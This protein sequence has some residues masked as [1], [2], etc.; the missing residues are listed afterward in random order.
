MLSMRLRARATRAACL[1]PLLVLSILA[2]CSED[3]GRDREPT[4]PTGNGTGQ[5]AIWT[6]ANM[7]GGISVWLDGRSV[8]RL[9]MYFTSGV[10][11]CGDE[12]TITVT[13]DAGAYD[14]EA[15]TPGG[16]SWQGTVNV[17]EGRCNL[18]ELT[19]TGDGLRLVRTVP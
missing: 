5:L 1:L 16:V 7:S 18:M 9:T 17:I 4:G 2:A 3:E 13:R 6:R 15:S 8:G 11:T 12:G 10:P 19:Y 14:L